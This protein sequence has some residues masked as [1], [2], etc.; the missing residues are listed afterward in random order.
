MLIL[1]RKATETIVLQ[2]SDGPVVITVTQIRGNQVGLG[3]VAPQSV[4]ILRGELEV[5]KDSA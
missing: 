4:R 5:R 1:S 2:T 3:I